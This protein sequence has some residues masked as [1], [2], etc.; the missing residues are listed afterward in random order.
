MSKRFIDT[1]ASSSLCYSM[2]QE[3]S[4]VLVRYG[5]IGIKSRQTRKFMSKLLSSQ[6]SSALKENGIRFSKIRSEFGRIFIMTTDAERAAEIAARVFG[7]VS[8]SPVVVVDAQLDLILKTGL[9]LARRS[10]PPDVS[11]AVGARRL[12]DHPFT[13]QDIRRKLGALILEQLADRHLTVDLTSP[14]ASVY[15]E[16]RDDVAYLFTET[17]QGVGGMPTGSQ[18][19]AVCIID[20][21]LSSLTAAYQVMKR[22]VIPVFLTFDSSEEVRSAIVI[23]ASYIHGMPLKKYTFD[24]P[25]ELAELMKRPSE[26]ACVLCR[27]NLVNIASEVATREIADAIGTGDMI[28]SPAQT[29][30]ALRV[31]RSVRCDFPIFQPC[32]GETPESVRAIAKRIGIDLSSSIDC[33]YCRDGA[34]DRGPVVGESFPSVS[35][36]PPDEQLRTARIEELN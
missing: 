19:T 1:R 15:V 12:G 8:S 34:N 16:V 30:E 27:R 2:N 14:Q 3:Y 28:G 24:H 6:I 18:G 4:A 29:L 21:S 9:S 23:L 25:S 31:I 17:I 13:S 11:F 5:E 36:P 10:F 7:V 35:L 26:E 33:S 20:G 32:A 22:G